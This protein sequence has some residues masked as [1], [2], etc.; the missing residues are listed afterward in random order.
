MLCNL[1]LL[2]VLYCYSLSCDRETRKHKVL[3]HEDSHMV[4][5]C[6][7][8][9]TPTQR[10]LPLTSPY[11]NPSIHVNHPPYYRNDNKSC[12]CNHNHLNYTQDCY[13]KSRSD[14][15]YKSHCEYRIHYFWGGK[16]KR[17]NICCTSQFFSRSIYVIIQV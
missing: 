15:S 8:V 6:T 5:T 10:L 4:E 2:S 9:C 14:L 13:R 11:R 16:K 7:F 3:H 1:L 17:K 12:R